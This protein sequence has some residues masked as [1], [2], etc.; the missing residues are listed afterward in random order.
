[1]VEPGF[2][3]SNFFVVILL[4]GLNSKRHKRFSFDLF[5]CYTFYNAVETWYRTER[6][7]L[8]FKELEGN[9]LL[10]QQAG[11]TESKSPALAQSETETYI[12]FG[13]RKYKA[14]SRLL[15]THCSFNA[16]SAQGLSGRF[17]KQVYLLGTVYHKA[18][19]F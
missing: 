17:L 11:R 15:V 2:R 16:P 18:G 3:T 19:T 14:Y 12:H 8:C 5:N 10:C 7:L 4:F 9:C 6:K 1:M 13:S